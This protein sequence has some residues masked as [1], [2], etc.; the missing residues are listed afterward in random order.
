MDWGLIRGLCFG[1]FT[2]NDYWGETTGL[3]V[4]LGFV[5]FTFNLGGW[6]GSLAR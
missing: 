6:N 3:V 5:Y 1:V 2:E 4:C